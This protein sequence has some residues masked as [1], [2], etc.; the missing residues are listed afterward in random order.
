MPSDAALVNGTFGH[1]L[2]YDDITFRML[3]HPGVAIF[4]ALLALGEWIDCG[5]SDILAA[6]CVGFEVAAKL[7][8]IVHLEHHRA[9]WHPTATLGTMGAAA[10]CSNLLRLDVGTTET[11]LGIAVSLASGVKQNFGTDTKPFH[12]GR[13]AS[14]GVTA[15]LL[16]SRGFTADTTIMEAEWGFYRVFVGRDW[17]PPRK[18]GEQLGAPWDIVDPGFTTKVYPACI[19]SH[20]AIR[21]TLDVAEQHPISV[22]DVKSATARVVHVTPQLLIHNRPRTGLQGKFSLQYSVAR[23]LTSHR[24][25]LDHFTDA[26]VNDP[27]ISALIE[28]VSM[29][30]DDDLDRE[31][32]KDQPRPTIVEVELKS[33]ETLSSRCDFPPGS[34]QK[35]STRGELETKFQDCMGLRFPRDRVSDALTLMGQLSQP[36]L[37]IRDVVALFRISESELEEHAS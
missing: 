30:V 7:G 12:A 16:A 34:P 10:A 13:A 26:A 5:A 3:G 24:V 35:P 31:W 11:A 29:V 23:A 27:G 21:A 22:G 1:A 20:T 32:K 25:G 4:P 37:R 28:R 6:Y 14:N 8:S 17:A 18:L 33:G 15:A 19:S 9:G 2:D 36:E